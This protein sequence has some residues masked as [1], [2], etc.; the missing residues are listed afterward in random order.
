[1]VSFGKKGPILLCKFNFAV[2]NAM[3][4]S[5]TMTPLSLDF[6]LCLHCNFIV[7]SGKATP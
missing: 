3:F 7:R 5:R 4:T 2:V 1:M 6:L